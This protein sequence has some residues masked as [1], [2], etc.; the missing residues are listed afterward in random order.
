MRSSSE[1]A[2]PTERLRAQVV[3]CA[4]ALIAR[5]G[6]EAT[7]I[8]EIAEAVGI[9]KQA[10]LHH[11]K[12]KDRIKDAVLERLLEHANKSF[13]GLM[14]TLEGPEQAQFEQALSAIQAY[15]DDQPH[16]A[17][18]LLRFIL[19]DDEEA[20][21]R[22]REG[23]LPW[24]KVMVEG[25]RHGEAEGRIR[26]GIDAEAAIAGIG[27]MVLTNF[28]LLPLHGWTSDSPAAWRKRRLAELIRTIRAVLFA[29]AP[30]RRG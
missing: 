29:E 21:S 3:D 19:D 12:S 25:L 8:A 24:F 22:I 14:S 1:L 9:S 18:V 28:A 30:K 16:A 17:R 20:I 7:S 2:T 26:K 6:F 4:A 15:F 11:F 10:L 23:A 5:R 13:L 27:M